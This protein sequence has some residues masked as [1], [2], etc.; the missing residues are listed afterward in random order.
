M[1][2]TKKY[3]GWAILL[4]TA[5]IGIILYLY[6]YNDNYLNQVPGS[7][8]PAN[9]EELNRSRGFELLSRG[10]YND[11][12]KEFKK[13][14]MHS[15]TVCEKDFYLLTMARVKRDND[16]FRSKGFFRNLVKPG[17]SGMTE[18]SAARKILDKYRPREENYLRSMLADEYLERM[19]ADDAI[20]EYSHLVTVLSSELASRNNGNFSHPDENGEKDPGIE[21]NLIL[22]RLNL[23]KAYFLKGDKKTGLEHLAAARKALNE[24]SKSDKKLNSKNMNILRY[25]IAEVY[26]NQEYYL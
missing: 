9:F 17:S 8:G 16:S 11:A 23:G 24:I 13:S 22:Y 7:N 20:M 5:G 4:I 25:L 14:I 10:Q 21:E 6:F 1:F 12:E 26:M 2:D 19:D 3:L 15:K 18:L